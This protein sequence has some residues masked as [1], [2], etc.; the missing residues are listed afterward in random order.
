MD[1]R[2][3]LTFKFNK[4]ITVNLVS[5]SIEGNS[6]QTVVL[7]GKYSTFNLDGGKIENSY[8]GGSYGG[9]PAFQ[10]GTGAQGMQINIKSGIVKLNNTD[11]KGSFIKANDNESINKWPLVGEVVVSGGSFIGEKATP[12]YSTD[13]YL[14]EGYKFIKV[15]DTYQYDAVHE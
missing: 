12:V 1:I 9:G 7:V 10:K 6:S 11:Y 2:Y 4:W 3:S 5:G 15:G 14:A 8:S 13:K